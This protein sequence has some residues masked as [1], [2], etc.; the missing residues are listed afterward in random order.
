MWG[1]GCG[2]GGLGGGGGCV[3]VKLIESEG[4]LFCS[5][6]V[7]ALGRGVERRRKRL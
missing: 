5:G 3:C 7:L 6:L 1:V 4:L 2:V